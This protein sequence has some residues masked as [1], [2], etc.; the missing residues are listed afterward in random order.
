MLNKLLT[1]HFYDLNIE[2]F[3]NFCIDQGIYLNNEENNEDDNK[4]DD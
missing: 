3:N 4:S 2:V 1:T